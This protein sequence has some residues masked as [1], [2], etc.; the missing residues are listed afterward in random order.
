[1]NGR[2]RVCWLPTS[3]LK[4]EKMKFMNL[5]VGLLQGY[6]SQSR[7]PV[8]SRK[9]GIFWREGLEEGV[10]T[11]LR[12]ACYRASR[13][14]YRVHV[15]HVFACNQTL[16]SLLNIQI[17]H[18]DLVQKACC[19]KLS[20]HLVFLNITLSLTQINML[21]RHHRLGNFFLS[22]VCIKS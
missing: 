18:L 6:P 9:R 3:M 15:T 11:W 22:S 13:D 20:L 2:L 17:S 8:R 16:I 7:G 4:T 14:G 5:E 10:Q 21:W 12:D 1:M 19:I